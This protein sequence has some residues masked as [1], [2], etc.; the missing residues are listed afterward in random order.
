MNK[1]G[2]YSPSYL[3]LG[4]YE[5]KSRFRAAYALLEP[6]VLCPRRCKIKRLHGETGFCRSGVMPVVASRSPHYGE[7]PPLSESRGSGTIFFTNCNLRCRFCQNYP[8]SQ[9]GV[10]REITPMELAGMML[11]LQ[12][13]ECH[14]VNLVTPSHWVPQI[15]EALCLAVERGFNLPLVYNSSGYDS[16]ETLQLL[17]GIVDI[18]LPDMKYHSEEVA[19][20]LSCASGYCAANRLAVLEMAR[21]VPDYQMDKEG[22]LRRGLII[23]HLILPAN[24]AQSK[25]IF[26]FI[27]TRLSPEIH[28]SLMTQYFPAHRAVEDEVLGRRITHKEYLNVKKACEEM[29]LQ[30]GWFQVSNQDDS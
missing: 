26:R 28:I 9:L 12:H 5:L 10:G 4:N 15:L 16:I 1:S 7:E 21:Q 11:W 24:K 8:I 23:R 29:G 19:G 30:K 14:N 13:R 25:E 17:E 27:A 20:N 18:Y 6:C 2:L 3:K 22:V